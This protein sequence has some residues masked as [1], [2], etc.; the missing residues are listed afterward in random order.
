MNNVFI[1]STQFTQHSSLLIFRQFRLSLKCSQSRR[2]NNYTLCSI[3]NCGGNYPIS[4][5]TR[6]VIHAILMNP[7]PVT[8][9]S[10]EVKFAR[11]T[12]QKTPQRF[13]QNSAQSFEVAISTQNFTHDVSH[14]RA[15][16]TRSNFQEQRQGFV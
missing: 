13:V 15:R 11:E 16:C 5:T 6:F 12:L 14:R 7:V 10:L 3:G 8:E 4:N 1:H 9:K 2:L